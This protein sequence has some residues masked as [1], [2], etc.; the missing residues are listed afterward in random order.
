MLF[1]G[2]EADQIYIEVELRRLNWLQEHFASVGN[3]SSAHAGDDSS[4]SLS[5]KWDTILTLSFPFL[6]LKFIFH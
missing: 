1:R 3:A 2:D 6:E 5:S 4:V